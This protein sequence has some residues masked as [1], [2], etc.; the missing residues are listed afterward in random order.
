MY[1]HT[2][3]HTHTHARAHTG[4]R[5]AEVPT[6]AAGSGQRIS[7][8]SRLFR[9][10]ADR[11]G[12]EPVLPAACPHEQRGDYS[13]VPSQISHTGPGPETLQS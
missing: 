3:T 8:R 11:R 12:E 4:I 10:H 13:G 2:H 9:P 6:E 1:A 7:P 5:Y